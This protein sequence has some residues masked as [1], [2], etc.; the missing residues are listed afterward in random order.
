[1]ENHRRA[2]LPC[3]GLFGAAS[4][5]HYVVYHF[6]TPETRY[7]GQGVMRTV[8][9]IRRS[10]IGCWLRLYF[11]FVLLTFTRAYTGQY[12]RHKKIALGF[13]LC[14]MLSRQG[15]ICYLMLKPYYPG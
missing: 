14:C 2:H 4:V 10:P 3:L 7:E 12:E 6:T 9:F 15:P 13:I 11:P 8:Y 5:A 1:M